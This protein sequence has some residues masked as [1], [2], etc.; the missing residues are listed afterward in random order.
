LNRVKNGAFRVGKKVDTTKA[1]GAWVTEALEREPS[2]KRL[3]M[4]SLRQACVR[5]YEANK[6]YAGRISTWPLAKRILFSQNK[7]TAWGYAIHSCLKTLAASV[8]VVSSEHTLTL[9]CKTM[10]P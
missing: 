8:S 3:S 4:F 10:G 9:R 5:R 6:A 1:M 2:S 7:F